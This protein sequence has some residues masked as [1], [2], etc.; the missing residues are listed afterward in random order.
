MSFPKVLAIVAVLLFGT[1]SIMAVWKK[2]KVDRPSTITTATSLE[3]DLDKE[4]VKETRTETKKPASVMKVKSDDAQ[5]PSADRIN[6]LFSTGV[7]KLPIV[8]TVSYTS[9]VSWLQG[10]PAWV[11]DYSNYYATSRHFIARSLNRKCD[12]TSQN[13]YE[14]A[15]FNVLRKD[16]NLQFYLVVDVSRCKMWFYYL[17]LDTNERVLLKDY[18]VGLGRPDDRSPSKCLTP[19]GKYQ[20]GHKLGIYKT[21]SLGV[22]NNQQVEM[23][24]VFGTRWIP[25]DQEI[26]ECSAPAKGFGIHGAPWSADSKSGELIE[27]KECIGKHMSDGCIRLLKD[28]M[29]EIFSIVITKP[30]IVEI[31]DDF[32]KAELPGHEISTEN[33]RG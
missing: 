18:L 29:E 32:Y 27:E 17:D 16:K 23:I 1:V 6:E 9:R 26:G 7:A 2:S 12:Y 5:L 3:I 10:R 11:V 19:L 31:V 22:F 4:I 13:I 15:K 20:L 30:T 28:N 24:R 21:G 25:F 14:G 33:H 8:E